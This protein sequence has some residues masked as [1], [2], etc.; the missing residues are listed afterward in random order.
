[1]I[2]GMR[3]EIRLFLSRLFLVPGF[4]FIVLIGVG[5]LYASVPQKGKN[6]E[7]GTAPK[8]SFQSTSIHVGLVK[9]GDKAQGEFIVENKG[10]A[11]LVLKRVAP[12]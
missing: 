7:S 6:R 2:I 3:K 12:T 8:I 1:M 10:N 11:D 5:I 4:I 9:P